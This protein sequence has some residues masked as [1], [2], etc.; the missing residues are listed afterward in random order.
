M[1]D[2]R[3]RAKRMKPGA[4]YHN[5]P[6]ESIEIGAWCSTPDG[7]GAPEQVHLAINL[8]DVPPLIMRFTGPDTLSKVIN[9][10]VSYCQLVWPDTI[11]DVMEFVAKSLDEYEANQ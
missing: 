6:L 10:L 9:E 3:P 4:W 5:I 1:N 11:Y 2:N 7:S 8:A